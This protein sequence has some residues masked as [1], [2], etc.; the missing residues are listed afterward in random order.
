[1]YMNPRR[2]YRYRVDPVRHVL[3]AASRSAWL[4][5]HA[6]ELPF[7][8]RGVQRFMPGEDLGDALEAL[9]TLAQQGLAGVLTEL[10]EGVSEPAKADAAARDYQEALAQV[11]A[12]GLDCDVSVKLT[13]LGCDIDAERCL[14]RVRSLVKRA[15]ECRRFVWIDMEQHSYVESTL[16]TYRQ[17]VAEFQNVGICLQAYLYRTADD[18]SSL[19]ERGG[20]VRLVKGAYREPAA[21]AYARKRDVDDNF[22]ALADRLLSAQARSAGVRAVFGTHDRRMIEAVQALG[23]AAS[24]PAGA[25]EFHMLYGIQRAEQVRLV[26]EG[27]RVRV[28]ISYGTQWFPWYMRRLAERPANLLFA[29]KAVFSTSG[30]PSAARRRGTAGDTP[31]TRP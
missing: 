24:I 21:V 19:I 5:H 2:G 14:A 23:S 25:F 15:T 17:L 27:Y 11:H 30:R 16:R 13:H 9:G 18:L 3:L 28:L 12:R 20:G 7:V 4:Q 10:G 26:R 31:G 6:A 1:M 22:L 8:R 29:A